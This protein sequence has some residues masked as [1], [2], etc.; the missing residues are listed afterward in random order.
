MEKEKCYSPKEVSEILGCSER[1]VV[2]MAKSG[3][4]KAVYDGRWFIAPDFLDDFFKEKICK[5]S[6]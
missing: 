4:I 5:N 1:K 2:Q 6:Q 3:R